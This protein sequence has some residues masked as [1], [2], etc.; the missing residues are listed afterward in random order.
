[1]KLCFS[2]FIDLFRRYKDIFMQVWRVRASLD[3]P[4]RTADEREFL[5]AHLELT[6]TP[7]SAAPK[8]VARL[9]MLFAFIALVWAI[10]G[11]VEIVAVS[12]GK[13]IPSGYSKV[14]QPLETSVIKKILVKDGDKVKKGDLL[15]ELAGIGSD[16]DY[17]QTIRQLNA[18]ILGRL[19]SQALLRGLETRTL[20]D[21]QRT[22][23]VSL[24]V[25]ET[26]LA[27]ARRLVQNQYQT[28][29]AQDEQMQTVLQQRNAELRAT[30]SQITKLKNLG[31]IEKQRLH[32]FEKLQKKNYLSQHELYQQQ[33]K[34]IENDQDLA[35]QREQL[36]Q[37]EESIHQVEKER[38]VN[39]QTLKRDTLD[40][41][42]QAN[43]DIQ[44][45]SEQV[46]KTRQRQTW[47]SLTSPVAGTV[48]QL[49]FHNEGGV[50]M[51]GQAIM[52]IAPQDD[53]IEV[54][55]M[56]E[57][58]DIGFVKAGQDVVVKIESFPYTRYGYLTGKVKHVS[59]DAIEDEKRGL[60]FSARIL[61]DQH[62]INVEGTNIPL[63]AGMN[64]TTEIKTGKRRVID[65]LL[66]PLQTTLDRSFTER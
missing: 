31:V 3:T 38:L 19:R 6:E 4:E 10:I 13:T 49:A 52:L 56:I 65:Y 36:Q 60:L 40:S 54:E 18:A 22:E 44:Q 11:Q 27:E 39:L 64:V 30:R 29:F 57:N 16:S 35:S 61:L 53:R 37:I 20:P 66:S 42:R 59:F 14:I 43:E 58:K 34:T 7:V 24:S 17:N 62:H 2:A 41:L 48:Q 46:D 12:A 28:W 55:T 47:M 8:C 25:S 26:E 51:E 21:I 63:N 33:S 23:A 32:D 5:P 1:M 15:I 9:I 45:L 50:V